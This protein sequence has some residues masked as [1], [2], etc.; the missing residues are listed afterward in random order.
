MVEPEHELELELELELAGGGEGFQC[1]ETVKHT[2]GILR[3]QDE[4][5]PLLGTGQVSGVSQSKLD[6]CTCKVTHEAL[7][8]PAAK[9]QET[10]TPLYSSKAKEDRATRSG[11]NLMLW[12]LLNLLSTRLALDAGSWFVKCVTAALPTCTCSSSLIVPKRHKLKI[13][14]HKHPFCDSLPGR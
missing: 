11:D 6:L 1:D 2:Q 10:S 5:L 4:I 3:G 14:M 8:S 7:C 12:D 13:Y 9:G